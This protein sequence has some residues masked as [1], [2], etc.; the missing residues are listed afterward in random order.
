MLLAVRVLFCNS[1]AMMVRWSFGSDSFNVGSHPSRAAS[2]ADC[3]TSRQS[4]SSNGTP[5][6]ASLWRFLVVCEFATSTIQLGFDLAL[7][8][9]KEHPAR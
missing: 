9:K 7:S 1:P 5:I 8:F 3:T 6:I 2:E 4:L